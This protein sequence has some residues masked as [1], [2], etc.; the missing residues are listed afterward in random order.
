MIINDF[1]S[2][3]YKQ[4]Y[5][6]KSFTP[7]LINHD[8]V[9]SDAALVS[10]LSHADIK[11]G[12]LNAFSELVPDVDFFIMMHIGKEATASS[13]IEGTQTNMEE[14]LQKKENLNPEKRADCVNLPFVGLV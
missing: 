10:L 1:K 7:N 13:R 14:I 11:L 2:G 8:W 9:V 6:Y 3:N 12:E 4:Q 5:K